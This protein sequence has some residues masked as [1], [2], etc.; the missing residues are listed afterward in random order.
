MISESPLGKLAWATLGLLLLLKT[1]SLLKSWQQSQSLPHGLGWIVYLF[2]WPGMRPESFSQRSTPQESIARDFVEGFIFFVCGLILHLALIL[3]WSTL[4]AELRLFAGLASFFLVIHFGFSSLLYT[5]YKLFGWPVEPL[6]KSP[7]KSS[8]LREFWS[9]RWNLAFVDMGKRIFLPLFPQKF[10]KSFAAFGIFIVSGV[11]HE[12]GIS[13]PSNGGWGLPFLYF[14]IHGV[15]TLIEP[16]IS[17]LN[18]FTILR[19]LWVWA[20]LLIPLPLLFHQ[21]FLQTFIFPYFE[22]MNSLV[23]SIPISEFIYW[24]I[25]TSGAGHLLILTASFQVPQKLNWK[26]DFARLS[27]FNQKIFWTYGGYI[28]FCIIAFAGVDLLN[29]RGLMDNH[30]SS[31]A[32]AGF[33]ALFWTVRVIVDFSYFKHDDWPKGDIFVIG[34]TCLTALFSCL[35]LLH[36][37]LVA[38]HSNSN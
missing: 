22:F 34:H 11:L 10:G 27:R 25:L 35:A 8:S 16:S 36:W 14:L 17:V 38:W 18:K 21:P 32:I 4:E 29:A 5:A 33:I 9:Q 37:G 19:R 30:P 15:L 3:F 6:F 23:T 12:I 7:L 2:L 28:V 13:F 24:S 1:F 20:A 31:T 26:T